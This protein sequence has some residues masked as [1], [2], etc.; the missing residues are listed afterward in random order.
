[1]SVQEWQE[2]LMDKLNL[3]GLNEWSSHNA[4]IVRELLLSYHDTFALKP[5][6][7][8]CTSAPSNMKFTSKMMN[9]SKNMFQA[10]TSAF[11]RRG[12]CIT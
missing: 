5:D 2:K 10:H 8:G 12:S 4:A 7:L 1:M 11:T 3:D 6:E 9:L